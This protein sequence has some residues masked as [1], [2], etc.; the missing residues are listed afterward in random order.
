MA[1]SFSNFCSFLCVDLR[2]KFGKGM[3]FERRATMIPMRYVATQENGFHQIISSRTGDATTMYI[4]SIIKLRD[5]S[6]GQ[7][8]IR[9]VKINTKKGSII[10]AS[11]V[12]NE[13][14]KKATGQEQ[15]VV[16]II[17]LPNPKTDPNDEPNEVFIVECMKIL[18]IQTAPST[19]C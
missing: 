6:G 2:T 12:D 11:F 3:M 13:L 1:K 4:T 9:N 19:S 16:K 8:I 10:E 17:L 7:D 14:I 15:A 18:A 5:T